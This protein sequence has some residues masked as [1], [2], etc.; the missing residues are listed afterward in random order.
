VYAH[1]A[2]SVFVNLY[3]QSKADIALGKDTVN[4]VQQ[5]EY[6]WDGHV[7]IRV[8]AKA[9]KDFTLML[10][11]PGWAQNRPVPSDLYA[12]LDGSGSKVNISL[13]NKPVECVINNK[14]YVAISRTW[15][16][17]DSVV[18]DFPMDVHRILANQNVADDN[19]RVALERGPIV[20]CLEGYDNG[21]QVDNVVLADDAAV[22]SMG[23]RPNTLNGLVELKIKGLKSSGNQTSA[24]TLLAI[25]YYAWA[26]RGGDAME[27]W[28]TRKASAAKAYSFRCDQWTS[29]SERVSGITYDSQNNSVSVSGKQGSN[30]IALQLSTTFDGCLYLTSGQKYLVVRGTSLSSKA[31]QSY[32][33]W[34]NGINRNT[35]VKPDFTYLA[36]DGYSFIVWDITKSGLNGNCTGATYLLSSN[37]AAYDTAFGLTSTASDNSAVIS[38]IAFYTSEELASKYPALAAEMGLPTAI[39]DVK[40]D[41]PTHSGIYTLSGQK[42]GRNDA[43]KARLPKGI[44]IVGGQKVVLK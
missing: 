18:I 21:Q 30:N 7:S 4:M 44:Y 35:N 16:S 19:G 11:I 15:T 31:D 43:S 22:T 39:G 40:A 27:V 5:S 13:N 20:Y 38:D 41:A 32:L 3:V 37:K 23:Y 24:T 17:G 12:Y 28:M 6:P 26:N 36:N 9:E 42:I 2:D 1:T 25:P 29:I 14:G 34:L 33:W 10:R 8:N